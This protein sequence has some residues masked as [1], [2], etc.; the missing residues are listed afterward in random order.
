ML[1][2]HVLLVQAVAY[3]QGSERNER[4]EIRHESL[5][6]VRMEYCEPSPSRIISIVWGFANI[7]T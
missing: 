6:K 2:G 7:K 5:S 1:E 4:L 3:M